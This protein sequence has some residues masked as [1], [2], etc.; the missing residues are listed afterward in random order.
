L[1]TEAVTIAAGMELDGWKALAL[2]IP[3]QRSN[4]LSRRLRPGEQRSL[5]MG[6]FIHFDD[7]KQDR[8][9]GWAS[10]A[11]SFQGGLATADQKLIDRKI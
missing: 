7:D 6:W 8:Y 5:R 9:S 10:F 2:A 3:T 4:R 11:V 1:D